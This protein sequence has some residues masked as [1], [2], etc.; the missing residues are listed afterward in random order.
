MKSKRKQLKSVSSIQTEQYEENV[1]DETEEESRKTTEFE[2]SRHDEI[3][4]EEEDQLPLKSS[5]STASASISKPVPVSEA[6]DAIRTEENIHEEDLD[7]G[8]TTEDIKTSLNEL[9]T[10]R[11]DSSEESESLSDNIVRMISKQEQQPLK[12][13]R[14]SDSSSNKYDEDDFIGKKLEVYFDSGMLFGVCFRE[15]S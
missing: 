12:E 5:S 15:R 4:E 3:E 10:H 6:A 13:A 11:R 2:Y 14:K 8:V 9:T 7:D 1:S